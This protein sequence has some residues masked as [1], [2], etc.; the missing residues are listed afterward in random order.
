VL[1]VLVVA[2]IDHPEPGRIG[3]DDLVPT[4]VEE[5]ADPG[6]VRTDLEDDPAGRKRSAPKPNNVLTSSESTFV[7]DFPVCSEDAIDAHSIS[8]IQAYRPADDRAMLTHSR[9]PFHLGL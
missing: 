2:L 4:L 9:P 6:G 8:E 5:S 3:D 1:V 7:F